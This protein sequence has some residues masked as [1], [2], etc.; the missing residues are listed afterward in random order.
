MEQAP[1]RNIPYLD[2]WRG[3]AIGTLL[4]GHFFPVPGINLAHVGVH[5]FFVLS[6][7]LMARIL[8]I[9]PMPLALF[10][11]RR[12]ARVF[13]T[14]FLF[15]IVILVAYLGSGQSVS[16][17]E[18]LAAATFLNNYFPGQP[19]GAVMPFGHI[20][21]LSVE[22]HSYLV[23]S[24]VALAVRAG[25][26]RAAPAVGLLALACATAAVA[27][28]L[29]YD[30]VRLEFDR[31]LRTEVA[32]YGILLSAC[33]LLCLEGKTLPRLPWPLFAVL[34]L[35]GLGTHWWA[36]A[37]PVTTVVGVSAF[38]L[39][40]NLL[41]AAP[42]LLQRLLSLRPLRQLGIWSF[43]IYVWQQPFYLYMKH[44]PVNAG[45]ACAAAGLAVATG[46]TGY[47]LLERPARS[48]LNRHWGRRDPHE[49]AGLGA[50]YCASYAPMS[51]APSTGRVAPEATCLYTAPGL[52]ETPELE[53]PGTEPAL[54]IS[55]PTGRRS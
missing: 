43:S 34:G 7:L 55:E 22:E 31:W 51:M 1:T 50:H 2:G 45:L 15:L 19:A 54:T 4:I 52:S 12:I 40:I 10:Y 5:L 33:L 8:F 3:V 47:Y 36:I 39:A 29:T 11:K 24:L 21:S 30:G 18:S 53:Y 26:V 35:L 23:L 41:P 6:G 9:N 28:W 20:W 48:W 42:P 13:P 25:R 46:I 37:L 49:N 17:R 14:V 44:R 27:Y 38:A 32:A 16:W